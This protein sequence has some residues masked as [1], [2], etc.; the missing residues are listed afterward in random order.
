METFPPRRWGAPLKYPGKGFN[1]FT[2]IIPFFNL[3]I[4]IMM[5]TE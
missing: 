1:D 3:A 5:Q 4:T 2:P